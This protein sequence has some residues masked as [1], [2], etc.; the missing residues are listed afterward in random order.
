MHSMR[1][2]KRL[3]MHGDDERDH[4][5]LVR[6][7]LISSICVLHQQLFSPT[8]CAYVFHLLP[9][10]QSGTALGHR[11]SPC[12]RIDRFFLARRS[13]RLISLPLDFGVCVVLTF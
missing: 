11:M 2:P 5:F 4:M 12:K 6:V 13:L 8:I 1:L 3:I 10:R 9:V 7:K